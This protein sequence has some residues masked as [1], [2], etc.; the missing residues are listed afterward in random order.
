M[1]NEVETGQTDQV[2]DQDADAAFAAGF[3]EVRGDTQ[4][5]RAE[6]AVTAKSDPAPAPAAKPAAPATAAPAAAV[7]EEMFHG[8]PVSKL[9]AAVERFEKLGDVDGRLKS[10]VDGK[11]GVVKQTWIPEALKGLTPSKSGG[12][13]PAQLER[14]KT[15]YPD[16]YEDLFGDLD[17]TAAAATTE[18]AAAAAAPA[19]LTQADL[20][21]AVAAATDNA[22]VAVEI[23]NLTKA[24][25]GWKETVNSPAFMSFM[26]TKTEEEIRQFYDSNDADLIGQ[27][28]EEFK[29]HT[30]AAP[31]AASPAAPNTAASAAPAA[32]AATATPVPDPKA[33]AEAARAAAAA[34]RTTRV[35]AAVTPKGIG[36]ETPATEDPDAAFEAG[37]DKVRKRNL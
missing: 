15:L 9:K 27:R 4:P 37:F 29:A 10:Y 24:H 5:Q 35:A 22:V 34:A 25:P 20:D 18:V 16:M 23:K 11:L 31:A 28:L 32:P 12:F 30:P 1:G 14:W 2:L 17:A 6:A 33:A 3:N 13:T 8:I 7:A 36:A 26:G 21:K 19:G